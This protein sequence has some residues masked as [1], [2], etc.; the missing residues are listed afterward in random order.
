MVN[1]GGE[2]LR[3]VKLVGPHKITDR[4]YRNSP[5]RHDLPV[6]DPVKQE[7]ILPMALRHE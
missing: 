4:T 2:R 6:R 1:I 7:A 5:G 3:D